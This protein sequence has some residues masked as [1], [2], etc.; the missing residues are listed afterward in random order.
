MVY[1]RVA[2]ISRQGGGSA[3]GGG[4]GGGGGEGQMVTFYFKADSSNT[5]QTPTVGP[6]VTIDA[7]FNVVAG[8]RP[9]S[10]LELTN[11]GNAAFSF[12]VAD[13]VF[14][15]AGTIGFWYCP[16]AR[17]D[18][19][20]V[21]GGRNTEDNNDHKLTWNNGQNRFEFQYEDKISVLR[22]M[23]NGTTYY[24]ELSWDDAEPSGWCAQSWVSVSSGTR[25]GIDNATGGTCTGLPTF[26]TNMQ[27]GAMDANVNRG[28][29]DDV[30]IS[31]SPTANFFQDA[32]TWTPPS[33]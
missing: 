3:G 28:I 9:P 19:A 31:T 20:A 5:P 6:S 26:D 22:N 23:A 17:N 7:G 33:R 29:Y 25:G 21:L 13:T 8:T 2:A 1:G 18:G 15:S 30:R 4:V 12:P 16:I 10:A 11:T 27:F 32:T 14:S 24:I